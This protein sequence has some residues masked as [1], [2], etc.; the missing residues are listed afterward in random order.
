MTFVVADQARSDLTSLNYKLVLGMTNV[1]AN[2]VVILVVSMRVEMWKI[3]MELRGTFDS[4]P[5]KQ[6]G[7]R[8]N[9]GGRMKTYL[10]NIGQQDR[11]RK[12]TGTNF[13]ALHTT[14]SSNDQ[15]ERFTALT[16]IVPD[17]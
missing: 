14:G 8:G 17:D 11:R 10:K 7:Y 1:I 16:N 6:R 2:P 9:G 15:A 4:W 12:D 3:R 5:R 13:L